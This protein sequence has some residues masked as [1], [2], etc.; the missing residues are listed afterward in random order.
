MDAIFI[1]FRFITFCKCWKFGRRAG[2]GQPGRGAR[3]AC[4]PTRCGGHVGWRRVGGGSRESSP[5][6]PS[7]I[8]Q[9]GSTRSQL[10]F[11]MSFIFLYP[12]SANDDAVIIYT[13]CFML[14]PSWSVSRPLY[15]REDIPTNQQ[16]NNT[17]IQN[18]NNKNKTC[19]CVHI[20]NE[21]RD[22]TFVTSS[23]MH[24]SFKCVKPPRL[25]ATCGQRLQRRPVP[26]G[27]RPLRRPETIIKPKGRER[28]D[29][30]SLQAAINRV[31]IPFQHNDI[32]VVLNGRTD[33]KTNT[34][35]THA[36]L[37][38]AGSRLGKISE[39]TAT[40]ERRTMGI[41]GRPRTPWCNVAAVFNERKRHLGRA[42]RTRSAVICRGRA[43]AILVCRNL[44][45]ER[46]CR[47]CWPCE[48][49]EHTYWQD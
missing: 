36:R 18:R 19:T 29:A 20:R 2:L 9:G 39:V 13:Q 49:C 28:R 15:M 30:T 44:Q 3:A 34:G 21:Y 42:S 24:F 32:G 14:S 26:E 46:G 43:V 1:D 27:Q 17:K 5:V 12:N 25:H 47:Q 35:R 6:P 10:S 33:G 8:A 31:V 41:A 16:Q 48:E 23:G 37:L 45:G 22:Y 38:Q 11:I 4:P 7:L 40:P